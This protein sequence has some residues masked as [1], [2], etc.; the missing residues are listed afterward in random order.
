[1]KNHYDSSVIAGSDYNRSTKRLTVALMGGP[2][3]SVYEYRNVPAEV[4]E[5]LT[6]ADSAGRFFVRNIR[7]S[8]PFVRIE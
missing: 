3:L 5:G 6:T 7:N 1:M 8:F 2:E 4:A